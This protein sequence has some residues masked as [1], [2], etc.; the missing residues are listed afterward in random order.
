MPTI[1]RELL[2][3]AIR[4]HFVAE[5][6]VDTDESVRRERDR[7]LSLRSDEAG[8]VR[9]ELRVVEEEIAEVRR[10]RRQAQ[11]DYQNGDLSAKLYSRLDDEYDAREQHA[12]RARDRLRDRLTQVEGSV[13]P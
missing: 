2:D 9:E 11:L 8:V 4:M 10:L 6:V 3:E 12:E 1:R 13:C 7:L 5:H